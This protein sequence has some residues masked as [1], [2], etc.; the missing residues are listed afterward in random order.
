MSPYKIELSPVRGPQITAKL[1][2][3]VAVVAP[4]FDGTTLPGGQSKNISS[5]DLSPVPIDIAHHFEG[6]TTKVR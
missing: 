4:D 6:R 1:P 2:Y 3:R 5:I